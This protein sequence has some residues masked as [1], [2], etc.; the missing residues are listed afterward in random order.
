L[1]RRAPRKPCRDCARITGIHS[2]PCPRTRLHTAGRGGLD[3]SFFARLLEKHSLERADQNRGR[4]RTFLLSS[5]EHFL[6]NEWEKLKAL[7][8]GGHCFFV[9]WDELGAETRYR[10][11]P[12]SELSTEKLYDRHWAATL[13]DKV[14]GVLR[15]NTRLA[16]S[17]RSS[18]P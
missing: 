10:Q 7:K 14:R 4:F 13:L 18:R 6:H 15:K 9:S 2:T 5:F 12:C 11:E 3:Q 16:E 1:I 8:R 17:C